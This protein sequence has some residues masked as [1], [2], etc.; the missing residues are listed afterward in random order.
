MSRL[1][2]LQ[3]SSSGNHRDLITSDN[4]VPLTANLDDLVS[5][6]QIC[7]RYLEERSE[8]RQ[9][10]SAED[11]ETVSD[12]TEFAPSRVV[13]IEDSFDVLV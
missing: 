5:R 12:F 9:T 6:R 10:I 1:S 7:L 8:A 3:P 11:I 4:I 13:L 2:S